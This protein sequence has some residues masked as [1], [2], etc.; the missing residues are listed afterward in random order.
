MEPARTCGAECLTMVYRSLGKEV[1]QEEIWPA[2]S[3]PNRFGVVS[4]TTHLMCQD[5]LNRGFA[6]V[7]FQ[8]RHPL[9]VLRICHNLGIHAILNHPSSPG[10]ARRTLFGSRRYR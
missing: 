2:I 10:C 8:A 1:K 4:S 3:K 7:A 9:Q 5:A 6:A